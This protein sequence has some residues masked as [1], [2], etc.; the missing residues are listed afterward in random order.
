MVI[1]A[2]NVRLFSTCPQSSDHTRET[3]LKTLIQVARWS[4]EAGCDGILVYADNG[5][6]DPWLVS[7]LVIQNTKR[8]APL[9]AVQ[10]A[11]MHPY[12]AA[13]MI[14]TLGFLH[15]RQVHLNMIA[16]GFVNDLTSLND[17]TPHD[18]RYDRL[19][20]YT[21]IIQKLLTAAHGI[22]YKGEFYTLN[23]ARM[24]PA[25]SADL[26][27]DIFMS[28]SSEAGLAAAKTAGAVAVKYPKAP[29]DEPRIE[30]AGARTGVRLGIIARRSDDQAWQVA[31]ARFPEDRKG[32]LAHQ[33]AMKTSDSA[34]HHQL[35]QTATALETQERTPYWLVPFQLYKTFCPYLVGSYGTV[36]REVSAYMRLGYT[37]FILDI[38]PDCEELSHTIQV[39]AAAREVAA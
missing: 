14:A 23:N 9:V 22:S 37:D 13:K 1:M 38:P 24:T 8:I 21:T 12:S 27:P 15:S 25:L 28:G 3:Y 34:W 20:E 17:A 18:R 32:R 5:I 36:A 33:L 2:T 16:G 11:Y 30:P 26:F 7:Q 4:D 19:L 31:H 35:S 10:P 6:A 39:F 29:A